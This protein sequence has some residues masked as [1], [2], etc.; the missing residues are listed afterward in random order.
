[1]IIFTIFLQLIEHGIKD[2]HKA[3]SENVKIR[4]IKWN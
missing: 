4:E 3:L 1:M 2:M